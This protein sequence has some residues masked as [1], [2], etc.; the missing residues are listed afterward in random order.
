M[1]QTNHT[2]KASPRFRMLTGDQVDRITRASFEI[3]E[4]VGFKVIHAGVRK[5][6]QSAGAIGCSD[7]RGPGAADAAGGRAGRA[8]IADRSRPISLALRWT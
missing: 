8:G 6:F 3:L 4:K 5:M 1:I 2:F 7:T